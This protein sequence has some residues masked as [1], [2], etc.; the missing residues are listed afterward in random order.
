MLFLTYTSWTYLNSIFI[1]FWLIMSTV[2]KSHVLGRGIRNSKLVRSTINILFFFSGFVAIINMLFY[3]IQFQL[4]T[5]ITA[6]AIF[7]FL[8]L[9][10]RLF[11]NFILGR[12]RAFGGNILKCIIVGTNSHGQ[13]LFNEILKYP[14]LGYR[15]KGIYS[16]DKNLN[17]KKLDIPFFREIKKNF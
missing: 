6:V 5:I 3:N 15:A 7:Y 16:F 8:I 10:Y 4:L 11:V 13:D 1:A 14:E 17:K 12:Y 9:T 2:S